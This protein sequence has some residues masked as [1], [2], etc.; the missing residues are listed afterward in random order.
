M[1][2]GII[3]DEPINEYHG[4]ESISSSQLKMFITQ[5]R[6]HYAEYVTKEA[7][8]SFDPDTALIGHSFHTLSLEGLKTYEA[9][10]KVVPED[11][12]LK[13]TDN[14]L[15]EH[16]AGKA[17]PAI[18]ERIQ[19]WE[20]FDRD[21]REELKPAMHELNCNMIQGLAK[22]EQGMAMIKA[23]TPEVTFRGKIGETYVQARADNLIDCGTHWDV[24]DVKTT[25]KPLELAQLDVVNFRY[26]IQ[27][28][29][30][31]EIIEKISG[32][33]VENFYLF[34]VEKQQPFQAQ[35]MR[36]DGPVMS[37][38]KKKVTEKLGEL[39][40]CYKNN[41]F[42]KPDPIVDCSDRLSTWQL[43]ELGIEL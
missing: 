26:D 39:M 27:A 8:S 2:L 29:F 16:R 18:V 43:R 22:H 15:K 13:P 36:V 6:R 32:K 7:P 14:M 35:L 23:G 42:P 25:S 24:L 12:P 9:T 28:A 17:K 19:W 40:D 34:F 37:N 5:R 21:Y 3:Y 4:N 10:Y 11:A 20:K 1:K 30:Y 41:S 31:S 33:P 38:A